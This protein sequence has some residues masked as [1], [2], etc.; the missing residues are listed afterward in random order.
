MGLVLPAGSAPQ[1]GLLSG[2]WVPGQW[3]AGTPGTLGLLL[4]QA[5][6]HPG[7]RRRRPDSGSRGRLTPSGSA[8]PGEVMGKT[9]RR[10][11]PSSGSP[12]TPTGLAWLLP[13]PGPAQP[14]LLVRC[15]RSP[16]PQAPVTGADLGAFPG[17]QPPQAGGYL[18]LRLDLCVFSQSLPSPLESASGKRFPR[19]WESRRSPGRKGGQLNPEE[20]ELIPAPPP[21]RWPA[22]NHQEINKKRFVSI[23]PQKYKDF[24]SGWSGLPQRP[25]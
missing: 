7:Q 6:R 2:R 14:R 3:G 13:A 16:G 12:K 9:C 11:A 5:Q 21:A 4:L 17:S 1:A 20:K 19:L 24:L 25:L 18:L 15:P 23:C 10:G 8:L 22:H